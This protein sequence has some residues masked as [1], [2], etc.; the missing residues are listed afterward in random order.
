MVIDYVNILM[1]SE[2]LDSMVI[3]EI[4]VASPFSDSDLSYASKTKR[5][6]SIDPMTSHRN[7]L[8]GLSSFEA[9]LN[10]VD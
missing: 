2:S 5:K 10:I 4:G 3:S 7:W 9:L 1:I 8:V 6:G